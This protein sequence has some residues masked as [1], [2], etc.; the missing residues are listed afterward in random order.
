MIVSVT[1]VF[2]VGEGHVGEPLQAQVA[3]RSNAHKN[4]KPITASKFGVTFKGCIDTIELQHEANEGAQS[5]TE[6]ALTEAG[7]SKAGAA[8]SFQGRADLTFR[9]GE[10]KVYTFPILFREAGDINLERITV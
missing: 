9:A 10:V 5:F 2:G 8:P 6:I 1:V 7:E 3:V 4:S